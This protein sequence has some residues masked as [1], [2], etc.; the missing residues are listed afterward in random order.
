MA[1]IV[2][3]FGVQVLAVNPSTWQGRAGLG[4]SG[5]VGARHREAFHEERAN[6]R[7]GDYGEQ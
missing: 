7:K 3:P 4:L 2:D 6:Q 5:G 1:A